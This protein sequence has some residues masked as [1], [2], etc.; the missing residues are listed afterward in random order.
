M[1]N[2]FYIDIALVLNWIVLFFIVVLIPLV[3]YFITRNNGY[4]FMSL[5]FLFWLLLFIKRA[6][7][8]VDLDEKGIYARSLFGLI[9]FS[10]WSEIE[11]IELSVTVQGDRFHKTLYYII[12]SKG[13]EEENYVRAFNKKNINIRVP[14]RKGS[15]NIIKKYYNKEIIDLPYKVAVERK[16]RIR[17]KKREKPL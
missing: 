13:N 16:K 11:K 10:S 1:R 5:N 12:F 8:W 4:L 9:K 2:R 14:A 17:R 6:F 3:V 7:Q 15:I